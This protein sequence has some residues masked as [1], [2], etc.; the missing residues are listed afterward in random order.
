MLALSQLFDCVAGKFIVELKEVRDLVWFNLD[1]REIQERDVFARMA[2]LGI[3]E[4]LLHGLQDCVAGE[5]KWDNAREYEFLNV[6]ILLCIRFKNSADELLQE[7]LQQFLRKELNLFGHLYVATKSEK[8]NRRS[9]K[10][11]KQNVNTAKENSLFSN[12]YNN[13][14]DESNA[15]HLVH[16]IR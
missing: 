15:A 1:E 11:M 9:N 6:L 7:L 8:G 14:G 3:G 2:E 10:Y 5:G 12:Y 4:C 13:D 16:A